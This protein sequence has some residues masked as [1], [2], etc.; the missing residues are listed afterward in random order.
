[1]IVASGLVNDRYVRR[2]ADSETAPVVSVNRRVR[3][4]RASVT[5]DD[6]AG[7]WTGVTHLA[8]LGHT[9]VGGVFGPTSIDTA[10]RR[11]AGYEA[12]LKEHNLEGVSVSRESWDMRAGY[13]GGLQLL[14]R[15]ARPTAIFA[16][17]LTMG[18][19]VL[20]A[21]LEKR[22]RVPDELSVIALHDSELADY[23]APPLTTVSMPTEE[24][25]CRS[26]ELAI[27]LIDGGQSRHVL[28]TTPPRVV[29][30]STTGAAP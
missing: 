11:K 13:E 16:P 19:G 29:L 15:A 7:A 23:L 22:V 26:A 14:R 30:R 27:E 21:A 17:S 3:G 1:L 28:I 2:L 4:L 9:R 8:T 12:A 6:A 18:I 20:R 25:G 5:V 10:R 24:M